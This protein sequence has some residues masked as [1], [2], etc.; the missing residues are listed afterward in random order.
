[1]LGAGLQG[2]CGARE[3]ESAWCTSEACTAHAYVRLR[4]QLSAGADMLLVARRCNGVAAESLDASAEVAAL[5]NHA[6]N[7]SRT[8]SH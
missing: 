3:Q 7:K 2:R 8:Q 5:C 6:R 4:L 1:M